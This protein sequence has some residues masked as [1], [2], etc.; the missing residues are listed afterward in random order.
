VKSSICVFCDDGEMEMVAMLG[1]QPF[2][3][4]NWKI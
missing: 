3:F 2:S 4:F 1:G